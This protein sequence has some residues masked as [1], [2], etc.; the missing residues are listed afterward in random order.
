MIT[1]I[2]TQTFSIKE[3]YNFREEDLE[4]MG[5]YESV[6]KPLLQGDYFTFW[7]KKKRTME[8]FVELVFL[9]TKPAS[10]F[11]NMK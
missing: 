2:D 3:E 5:Q 1:I 11:G 9:I 10:L 6:Y 4:G 8:A 7:V